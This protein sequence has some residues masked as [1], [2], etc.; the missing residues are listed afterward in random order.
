MSEASAT[1]RA[2]RV[3]VRILAVLLVGT[4]VY[5]AW[6]DP[7][8]EVLD[9]AARAG[10][11]GRF[12]TLSQGVTHYDVAGPDSGRAVILVHG[13]SVP[14][15]IWDSTAVALS[16]AGY[17]VIRYDLFGRGLSD[18]PNAAYDGAFYD[19]QLAELADSLGVTGTFDLMGLS[20][21]G[22]VTAH[23][24]GTHPA[25]VRTLTLVDPQSSGRSLPGLLQVPVLGPWLFQV[26]AVPGMA[27]NQASDFLHPEHF[28][29]WADLYRPQMRYKGFGRSLLRSIRATGE[30]DFSALFGAVGKAGIPTLLVWGEQDTTVPIAMS[31][32]ARDAIPQLEFAPIDSSGHL[33]HIEQAGVVRARMLDFL[34]AH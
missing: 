20:F 25:R 11:S 13:F 14:Y 17:R 33:P 15:Y 30:T 7:E 24:T 18:R 29:G 31:T 5:G 1:R 16:A 32:V 12:I 27:D 26:T 10:A 6:K 2:L 8:N 21:G 9:A 28:P 22:F 4:I 23:F 3:V 19:A 34:A